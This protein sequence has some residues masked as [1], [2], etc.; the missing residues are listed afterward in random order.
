MTNIRVSFLAIL[1]CLVL[2]SGCGLLDSDEPAEEVIWLRSPSL[3]IQSQVEPENS[4]KVSVQVVPGLDTDA[5][6][7]MDQDA[8]MRRHASLRWQDNLPELV[9]MLVSHAL[10]STGIYQHVMTERAL[11]SADRELLLE[12]RKF[13]VVSGGDSGPVVHIQ[14]V[15][16]LHCGNELQAVKAGTNDTFNE[17]EDIAQALQRSLSEALQELASSVQVAEQNCRTA[18]NTQDE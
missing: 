3:E 4:L 17:G 1:P 2:L 8:H 16:Q 14:M 12:L 9:E 10:E 18:V 6:L 15:G 5:V 13:Y 11:E 7:I